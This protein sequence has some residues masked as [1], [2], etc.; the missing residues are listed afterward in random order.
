MCT[1]LLP[2]SLAKH[3]GVGLDHPW[4]P[5][6][7]G[8]VVRRAWK[9]LSEDQNSSYTSQVGWAGRSG[10]G[11]V[12]VPAL[13]WGLCFVVGKGVGHGRGQT[14]LQWNFASLADIALAAREILISEGPEQKLCCVSL[15]LPSVSSPFSTLLHALGTALC[16]PHHPVSL[17]PCISLLRLL[18]QSTTE[19]VTY[20]AQS[21]FL[22]VLEAASPRS[23]CGRIGFSRRL[24]L[25]GF[26]MVVWSVS[27]HGLPSVYVC[28][29]ISSFY[30][31]NSHRG[32]ES[33][34]MTS[35]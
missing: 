25:L 19:W 27:L 17:P 10:Q 16:G 5:G 8:Y 14:L 35:F 4:R 30:K 1:I 28:F 7:G 3:A 11:R 21:Y 26:Y 32:S 9:G 31:D 20:A 33:T 18:E 29:Q 6:E 22:T 15:L 24:C 12:E 13:W 23:K 2:D 34:L